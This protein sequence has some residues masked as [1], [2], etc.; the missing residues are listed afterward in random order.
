MVLTS[1]TYKYTTNPKSI[2]DFF[3]GKSTD[4]TILVDAGSCF[5]STLTKILQLTSGTT[6]NRNS[7]NNQL[8]QLIMYI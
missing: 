3:V 5:D 2:I 6:K 1:L 8:Q 7:Q 4:D